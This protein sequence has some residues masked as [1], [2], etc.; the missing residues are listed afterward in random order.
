MHFKALMIILFFYSG[1]LMIEYPHSIVA[2][3][4]VSPQETSQSLWIVIRKNIAV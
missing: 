1:C 4:G 2:A 3:Q